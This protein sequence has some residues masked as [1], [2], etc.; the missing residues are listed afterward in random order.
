MHHKAYSNLKFK[1]WQSVFPSDATIVHLINFA[2][3]T[4][5]LAIESECRGQVPSPSVDKRL[6]IVSARRRDSLEFDKSIGVVFI[7]HGMSLEVR[8]FVK[9]VSDCEIQCAVGNEMVYLE[10]TKRN[11]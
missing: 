8:D 9:I 5:V 7:D 6:Q 10:K 11:E 4:S 1:S 3:Q 2:L